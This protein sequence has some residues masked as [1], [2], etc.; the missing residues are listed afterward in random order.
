M[1]LHP[2]KRTNGSVRDQR[3]VPSS[4]DHDGLTEEMVE[5]LKTL[6]LKSEGVLGCDL[7]GQRLKTARALARKGYAQPVDDIRNPGATRFVRTERSVARLPDGP[8]VQGVKSAPLPDVRR[9]LRGLLSDAAAARLRAHVAKAGGETKVADQL[10]AS[11]WWPEH[12]LSAAE[13][14]LGLGAAEGRTA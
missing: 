9:G 6:P 4:T 12:G 7:S 14:A 1:P 11:G 2:F 5:L 10:R 13:R 3:S 8:V